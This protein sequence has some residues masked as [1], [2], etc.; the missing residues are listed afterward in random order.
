MAQNGDMAILAE[1]TVGVM[2]SGIDERAEL[3]TELGQ[4]LAR[5]EVNLLTGGG[6]G[7]MRAVSRA[8]RES[9]PRKGI[10]I[11][12][13]PCVDGNP[14]ASPDGYPNDYVQLAIRTHLPDSGPRGKLPSSRNHINVLSCD[15]VVALPGAAGTA[16]EVDLAC[17]YGKP[18]IVFT[19][20]E[21][22]VAHFSA[23][24]PRVT[25]IAEVEAFLRRYL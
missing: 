18:V 19:S 2:G 10:C 15:A 5:L 3:A 12:V 25:S 1:K 13:L 16:T 4:L 8:Y 14:A 7:V 9:N 24:A 17:D 23:R 20:D 11:G 22:L 21:A 6:K